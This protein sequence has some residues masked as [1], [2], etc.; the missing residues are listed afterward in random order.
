MRS[1][2]TSIPLLHVEK[3]RNR[4]KDAACSATENKVFLRPHL[5][6]LFLQAGFGYGLPISRLYARYFQ[7]DLQ[8]FSMEGHGTDA[9]IFLKV[10][11]AWWSCMKLWQEDRSY[12]LLKRNLTLQTCG[13]CNYVLFSCSCRRCLQTPLRGC[14]CTTKLLW[15]TTKSAR[16]LTTGAYPVKNPWI[17][18]PLRW[19][20]E[21]LPHA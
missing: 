10:S 4:Q 15:R 7:G 18:A 13:V 5:L 21:N 16:R 11:R 8:L 9:V 6:A 1:F 19:P 14:Q 12:K 17:W 20:S 3:N 2:I